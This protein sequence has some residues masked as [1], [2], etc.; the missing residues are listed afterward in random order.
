[1]SIQSYFFASRLA[2]VL[3]RHALRMYGVVLCEQLISALWSTTENVTGEKGQVLPIHCL[4]VP[5]RKWE[6]NDATK[7]ACLPPVWV[8]KR[9]YFIHPSCWTFLYGNLHR[10]EDI[11]LGYLLPTFICSLFLLTFLF[12]LP[13][14]LPPSHAT[15]VSGVFCIWEL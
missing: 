4:S 6:H 2:S 12:S 11:F 5:T 14:S 13:P 3:W 7:S 9:K 15:S 1:M 8:F 10:V